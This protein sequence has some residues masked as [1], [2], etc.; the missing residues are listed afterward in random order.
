MPAELLKA[1][2]AVDR[3]YRTAPFASDRERVEFLFAPLTAKPKRSRKKA[4]PKKP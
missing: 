3:C 2:R 1:H 4:T